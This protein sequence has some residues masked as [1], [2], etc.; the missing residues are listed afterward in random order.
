M[1]QFARRTPDIFALH[2]FIR[3]CDYPRFLR[4]LIGSRQFDVV[5]I[6]NSEAGYLLL[7]YLRAHC[8]GP[9]YVDYCHMEE[10]YWKNGGYPRFAAGSQPM[11]D[12]N[13]VSSKHLKD[14]KVSPGAKPERIEVGLYQH[15]FRKVEAQS[16][17]A[18]EAPRR[19]RPCAR[20][21]VI[22]NA[23]RIMSQKQPRV[24]AEAMRRLHERKLD[25]V[26]FVARNGPDLPWLKKIVA[27][28]GMQNHVRLLGAMPNESVR[29]LMSACDVFLF[30]PSLQEGIALAIF[31]AMSMELTVVGADVGG[32]SEL[33]TPDCGVL[34]PRSDEHNE[35][36]AY[37]ERLAALIADPEACRQMARR[38]RARIV[39]FFP[40]GPHGR[41]HGR[42]VA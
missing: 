19:T 13:I 14:W 15:R 39:E 29:E 9:A 17:G 4:Y 5:L 2:H 31:E 23:C 30:L 35:A 34:L 10:E 42:F 26:A 40:A 20:G 11:L 38:A 6:T 37:A 8:P 41:A 7:P 16:G 27:E 18:P 32:Q 28:Y 1:P 36:I 3:L 21:L 12:L 33:V 22:L 24:F 25:F